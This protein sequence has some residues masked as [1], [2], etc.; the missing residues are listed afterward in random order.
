MK[1][2]QI[3]KKLNNT[4]LGKAGTNDTY[5]HIPNELNVEEIFEPNISTTFTDKLTHQTVTVRNT[6][7]REKRIVGLGEY[8]RSHNLCA[9]DEI[10]L[11][12]RELPGGDEY[13]IDVKQNPDSLV[14]Q[15]SR[16]GFEIL[17][18]QRVNNFIEKTRMLERPLAVNFLKT[19][20]KRVD[21][22]ET[23]DY[24]DILIGGESILKLYSG[25]EIGEIRVLGDEI[26]RMEFYGW[27]K[28]IFDTEDENG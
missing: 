9:G 11:E 3:M 25:K 16:Y 22:P 28:Y 8:Y 7:G 6:V 21:S 20:H 23:T 13:Y 14:F 2:I 10:I 1:V 24:F 5:V 15:K 18:P 27:K 17:T 19:A 12:K 4:E 26:K